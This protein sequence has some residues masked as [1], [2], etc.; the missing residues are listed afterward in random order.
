MLSNPKLKQECIPVGC[1]PADRWLYSGVC[2]PGGGVPGPGGGCTWSGEGG[3]TWSGGGVYLVR[4][5]GCTW[6]QGGVPGPGGGGYLVPGGVYLV[7]GGVYCTWSRGGWTWSGGVPG[8]GGVCTWSRGVNLVP[9]GGVPGPGGVYLVPGGGVPGP[10]GGVPGPGGCTWSRGG[11]TWSW[12]GVYLVPGGCTWSGGRGGVPGPRGGVPG[13]GGCSWSRGGG[14]G[15]PGPGGCTWSRGGVPGPGGGYLVRY[16]PPPVN[17]MT[18]RCKNITLAKTSFRP[19]TSLILLAH[20]QLIRLCEIGLSMYNMEKKMII[21]W[22][23][24]IQTGFWYR[25]AWGG[26]GWRR[27]LHARRYVE[28]RLRDGWIRQRSSTRLDSSTTQ[29]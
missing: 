15:A 10:G 8:P 23:Q 13:P 9:G 20:Q 29:R 2:S 4:W 18:N 11:C 22:R 1:V 16:S 28:I 7:P 19:V 24:F 12:G 21:L 3:C 25:S 26:G 14:G 5:G 6:S 17:R 27:R